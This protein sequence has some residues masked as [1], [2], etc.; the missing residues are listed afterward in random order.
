MAPNRIMRDGAVRR[1]LLALALSAALSF[2][3]VACGG[4]EETSRTPT[5]I[6][7]K[8]GDAAILNE[9]LSRQ[10]AVVTAYDGVLSRLHEPTLD[11]A[12]LFRAQEQEHIDATL[13]ALR[14]LGEEAEPAA[15]PIEADDLESQVDHL[16]FLYEM[17]SATIEAELTA[18]AK[19]TSPSPRSMLA[20]TVANQAQHLVLLRRALGAKPLKAVPEPFENGATPVP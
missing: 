17:E 12:R 14:G 9:I 10:T 18:V 2:A 19:L 4:G 6:P 11:A 16:R 3:L 5:A 15:E 20:A 1:A 7:D 8:E 13:K